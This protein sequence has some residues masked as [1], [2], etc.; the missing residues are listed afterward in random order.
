MR[1]KNNYILK[2]IGENIIVVPLKE[3]ALRFNGIISLNQSGKF[4][5]ETLQNNDLNKDELLKI[6]LDKYE[7]DKAVAMKDIESFIKQCM[8]N[9]LFDE[10]SI[11]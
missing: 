6:V 3:E 4:L 5:F 1:I 11:W 7:V 8:D 10:N 2:T 9:K